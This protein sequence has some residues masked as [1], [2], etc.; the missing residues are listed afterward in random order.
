VDRFQGFVGG[1]GSVEK[2][3]Y[4]LQLAQTVAGY[5]KTK[6]TDA[7][8]KAAMLEL[9]GKIS[10][11]LVQETRAKHVVLVE[12]PLKELNDL[13]GLL[14]ELGNLDDLE[15]ILTILWNARATQPSWPSTAVVSLG[16]RLV[17]VQFT[18]GHHATAIHLCE[19]MCYNLRRVWGALDATTLDMH[20]LLSEFF[21]SSGQFRKAMQVH[22]DVLRD[23]VSDKGEELKQSE[24]A[25]IA[26]THLELLKRAYQRLGKWDKDPQVYIDLYQQLAHVFGSE[27]S[28]KKAQIQS[29]DKW[30]S[31][32]ADD[33][34]VWKRPA[35]FEWME[36]K[37]QRKHFNFLRKSLGGS[38]SFHGG[39]L[40]RSYSS[41][42]IAAK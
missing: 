38:W 11:Q 39:R 12:I 28:W 19:D 18:R 6:V 41:R 9:A 23:T 3:N 7:K 15:Y 42:S 27:E 17:D 14:G 24:A 30:S 29:L 26:V 37:S 34:G 33:L 4:G 32:G 13:G 22:E 40:T 2:F 16:H 31:K 36:D 10:K 25:T 5:K 8:L 1:Y 21:T 35:S 20:T